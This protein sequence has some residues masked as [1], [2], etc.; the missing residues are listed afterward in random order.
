VYSSSNR[1]E[2][3]RETGRKTEGVEKTENVKEDG[4]K[5][6]KIYRQLGPYA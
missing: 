2:K 3:L 4:I 1:K 6:N 5:N